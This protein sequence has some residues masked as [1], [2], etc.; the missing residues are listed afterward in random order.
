MDVVAA[1]GC[2]KWRNKTQKAV[3]GHTPFHTQFAMTS[4]P[5][6]PATNRK[7]W[8]LGI[9]AATPLAI[10]EPPSQP[11]AEDAARL[12]KLGIG[13]SGQAH[14]ARR[15]CAALLLSLSNKWF[16]CTVMHNPNGMLS[17]HGAIDGIAGG[18]SGS[19]II[20]EDGTAIGIVCLA[21]GESGD[22]LPTEGGPNPRLTGNLPGW[23]LE[24]LVPR[25]STPPGRVPR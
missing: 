4:S 14:R 13:A 18:M 19:P 11:A 7:R 8:K 1:K 24:K 17:I 6:A 15:E 12:A 5:F 3:H 25:S 10:A 9:P 23:L 20:A 16:P 21:G 22:D 2:Q